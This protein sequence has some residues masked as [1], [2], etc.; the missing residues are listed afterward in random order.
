MDVRIYCAGRRRMKCLQLF[1]TLRFGLLVFLILLFHAASPGCCDV[2]RGMA[3]PELQLRD[4]KGNMVPL[5]NRGEKKVHLIWLTDSCESCMAG[6][7]RLSALSNE[8]SSKGVKVVIINIHLDESYLK[9][10][11]TTPP[12][13]SV[14][15]LRDEGW[16]VPRLFDENW[17]KGVCPLKN[18]VIVDRDGIVQCVRHYP[19]IPP[20][21]LRDE[22]KTQLQR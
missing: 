20:E 19:G 18:L 14:V 13:A 6:F 2:Q 16:T 4:E 11:L 15:I 3:L 12:D 21:L 22:L 9:S 1:R 7:A 5:F 8:Y 10:R 17:I